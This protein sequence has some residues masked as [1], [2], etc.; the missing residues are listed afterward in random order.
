MLQRSSF[1]AVLRN[2]VSSDAS[3]GSDLGRQDSYLSHSGAP[4]RTENTLIT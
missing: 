3:M 4:F 1:D 2:G